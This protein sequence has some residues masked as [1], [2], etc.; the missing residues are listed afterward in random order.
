ML[1][2]WKLFIIHCAT[3]SASGQDKANPVFRL[4][5]LADP[6]GIAALVPQEKV[7]SLANHIINPLLTKLARSR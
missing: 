2:K 5:T 3:D 6:L 1:K 7:L 4:V